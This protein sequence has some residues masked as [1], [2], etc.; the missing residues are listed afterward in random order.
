MDQHASISL[1]VCLSSPNCAQRWGIVFWNQHVRTEAADQA[2]K[3]DPRVRPQF[4]AQPLR[5]LR[6]VIFFRNQSVLKCIKHKQSRRID[7]MI[8]RLRRLQIS[9]KGQRCIGFAY[10]WHWDQH[11][12][13]DNLLFFFEIVADRP[14]RR[15]AHYFKFC[16]FSKYTFFES[17]SNRFSEWQRGSGPRASA[18]TFRR[19]LLWASPFSLPPPQALPK[20][21][22]ALLCL[23][24]YQLLS[25]YTATW[26]C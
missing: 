17:W 2:L 19:M 26:K 7:R 4:L 5:R 21:N 18:R 9:E 22:S 14:A 11:L 13:A 3:T 25:L 16:R 10:V 15:P 12:R 6:R 20:L 24:V 23:Q 1:N 8:V